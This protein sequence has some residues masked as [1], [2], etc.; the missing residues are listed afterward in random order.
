MS[1]PYLDTLSDLR[2]SG[3]AFDD[4]E[5]A[6]LRLADA[7]TSRSFDYNS[8][9]AQLSRDW[10][11]SMS[12]TAHQREVQDLKK[13]GLNPVLAAN[14][15]AAS[16]SATSASGTS[17]NSG[18]N[19]LAA[20][21]GSKLSSA[22]TVKAARISAKNAQRVAQINADATR[23]ASKLGYLGQLETSAASRYAADRG[24][25]RTVYSTDYSKTG[26]WQGLMD[27]YMHKGSSAFV[28]WFKKHFRKKK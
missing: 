21:A 6:T 23:F 18:I 19:A 13:A 3:Y 5:Y 1:N 16:Y 22:A 15:G 2:N 20:I 25:E 27:N 24:Y 7:N 9:E 4:K 17:D 12:N 10:Q 26:N 14:G 8:R 28:S 11:E